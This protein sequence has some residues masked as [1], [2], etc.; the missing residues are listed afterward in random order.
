M[1]ERAVKDIQRNKMIF[2]I[3]SPCAIIFKKKLEKLPNFLLVTNIYT[4]R[5]TQRQTQFFIVSE[6]T[7]G[8]QINHLIAFSI[9]FLKVPLSTLKI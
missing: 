8:K 4:V 3:F 2:W 9:S 1:K 6:A 7:V 5:K